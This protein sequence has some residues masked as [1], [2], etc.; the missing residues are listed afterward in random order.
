MVSTVFAMPQAMEITLPP[1]DVD[2]ATIEV[3]ESNLLTVR[4]DS[5]GRYWWNIGR[6]S[7]NLPELLPSR[8]EKPDSVAYAF[9]EDTLRNLL[10]AQNRAND[11]LNTLVLIHPLANY[12]DMVNILDEIDVLERSWNDYTAKQKGIEVEDLMAGDKFSY[13]YATGIWEDR[14][15]K[16]TDEA[17]NQARTQGKLV[18]F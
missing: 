9:N 7:E 5:L 15:S 18:G 11:K 16:I 17:V 14:D 12:G 13:R 6:A 3:K 10:V 8:K 2:T 1:K 4:V